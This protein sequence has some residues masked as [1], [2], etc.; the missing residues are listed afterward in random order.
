[1][2][3]K[4][5]AEYNLRMVKVG[6]SLLPAEKRRVWAEVREHC[7]IPVRLGKGSRA[8]T[9][10]GCVEIESAANGSPRNA[11]SIHACRVSIMPVSFKHP[12]TNDPL[13][14]AP[15]ARNERANK[16]PKPRR[17]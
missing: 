9:P 16:L 4:H 11:I 12:Q 8:S 15:F 3:G 5:A 10:A 6:Y 7:N 1:M 13:R 2:V 17:G 14:Q